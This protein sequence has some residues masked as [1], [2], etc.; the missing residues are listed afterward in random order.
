[1]TLRVAVNPGMAH[2]GARRPAARACGSFAGTAAPM[3]LTER[4]HF[5]G[6]LR[7]EFRHGCLAVSDHKYRAVGA[8][9]L[10]NEAE[11]A[12]ARAI[13]ARASAASHAA[14]RSARAA[15]GR[16]RDM[17]SLFFAEGDGG[18]VESIRQGNHL[19]LSPNYI[20]AVCGNS[21]KGPRKDLSEGE[22]K[23]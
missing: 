9:T 12:L 17:V 5:A 21:V 10:R 1:M 3:G 18:S 14:E 8:G 7:G 22:A 23:A 15:E 11:V 16:G 6:L 13:I 19:G 20:I 4:R 2:A